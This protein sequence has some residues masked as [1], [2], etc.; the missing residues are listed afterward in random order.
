MQHG[1]SIDVFL[2]CLS[3]AD[4]SLRHA[5]YPRQQ[6]ERCI[7]VTIPC[8]GMVTNSETSVLIFVFTGNDGKRLNSYLKFIHS[9]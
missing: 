9:F 3:L 5:G 2:I 7:S 6:R 8:K 4:R 1:M